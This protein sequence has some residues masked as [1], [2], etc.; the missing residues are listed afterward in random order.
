[1]GDRS[2]LRD[3]RL[4]DRV[5]GSNEVEALTASTAAPGWKA[6]DPYAPMHR[7]ALNEAA[8]AAVAADTGT[9]GA[10]VAATLRGDAAFLGEGG[11]VA[12]DGSGDYLDLGT[13][14]AFAAVHGFTFAAWVRHNSFA[15]YGNLICIVDSEWTNFIQLRSRETHGT[16]P[17]GRPTRR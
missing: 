15:Q 11:G 7:W 2:H 8:G 6:W 14:F 17:T 1:M 5:L 13:A 16:P 9:S 10:P 3:V 12:L 4:Y